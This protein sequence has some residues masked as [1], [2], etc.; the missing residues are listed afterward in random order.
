MSVSANFVG[1]I[2]VSLARSASCLT[3]LARNLLPR[4]PGLS[5]WVI[6]ATTLCSLST[7]DSRKPAA[8]SGV[9]ANSIFKLGQAC[10]QLRLS[11][12]FLELLKLFTN[13]LSLGAGQV[14]DEEFSFEMIYFVLYADGQ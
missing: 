12:L 5:G 7:K 4:L 1:C 13:E 6:T 3:G 8:N 11:P 2:T 9:P 10:S 14:V